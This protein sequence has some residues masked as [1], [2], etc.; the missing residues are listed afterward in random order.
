MFSDNML[1]GDKVSRI[2]FVF[3]GRDEWGSELKVIRGNRDNWH[4]IFLI[5]L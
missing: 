2:V 1:R 3:I 5:S 4:I